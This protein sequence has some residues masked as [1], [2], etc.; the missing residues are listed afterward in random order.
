MAQ[1]EIYESQNKEQLKALLNEKVAVGK[2]CAEW[3]E[4]WM[5]ASEE[6]ERLQSAL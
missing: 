5:E 6:L 3:E 2:E 1:P 4:R